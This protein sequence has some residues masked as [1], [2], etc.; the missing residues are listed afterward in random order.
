MAR[1]APGAGRGAP[2]VNP[3]QEFER[4]RAL[5]LAGRLHEARSGLAALHPRC[6]NDPSAAAMLA[7]IANLE[8]DDAACARWL[9]ETYAREPAHTA[10][11]SIEIELALRQG[12]AGDAARVAA[13]LVAQAPSSPWARHTL[14]LALAAAGDRAGALAALDAALALDA[15]HVPAWIA[16]G[17]PRLAIASSCRRP[18][19]SRRLAPSMAAYAARVAW[20]GAACG[21]TMAPRRCRSSRACAVFPAEPPPGAA[22]P[23]RR[24]CRAA[25]NRWRP[26]ACARRRWTQAP[27]Q[28]SA[29]G[30]DAAR[31]DLVDGARAARRARG[32]AAPA[33]PLPRWL[34]LQLLPVVYRDDADIAAWRGRWREGLAGFDAI[35]VAATQVA[36]PF[37]DA[38]LGPQLLP[39]LPGR[40]PA[41]GPAAP[42]RAGHGWAR[43]GTPR[44]A[45]APSARVACASPSFRPTSPSTVS[46]L[47]GGWIVAP[48]SRALR[49]W[50][51]HLGS[52]QD[53]VSCRWKRASTTGRR[54]RHGRRLGRRDRGR[55]AR[56]DG[57]AR[58]RH[59]RPHPGAVGATVRAAAVRGV[60]V[61]R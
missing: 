41:R 21:S 28:R 5:A 9:A 13:A 27:E 24:N 23:R 53:A 15:R 16:R 42:R 50:S 29:A 19:T 3:G 33:A 17:V 10:A 20:P 39:P 49:G 31:F 57:I 32:R 22:S 12:R 61:I 52:R 11:R 40:D 30:A 26:R 54:A 1:R 47:F 35:E 44:C 2:G 55:A 58:H 4:L 25:S 14:G 48:R 46:Q 56:R 59:G 60:G 8:R 6:G 36:A 18:R 37:P 38:G 34:A 45:P 7:W 43:T 51:L